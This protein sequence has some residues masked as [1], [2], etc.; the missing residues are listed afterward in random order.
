MAD[1]WV[2]PYTDFGEGRDLLPVPVLRAV[3]PVSAHGRG[4]TVAA[5][6]DT[7]G[8]ITVVS[9][10]FLAIAGGDPAVVGS[11]VI[12]LGGRRYEANLY[13]LS[14]AL[15]H[16]TDPEAAPMS[17]TSTVAVLDPWPHEGTAMIL[18]HAGFLDRFTVTFG[19]EGFAVEA[20]EV[21]RRRFG[22]TGTT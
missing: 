18:G 12:R 17:W 5:I 11:T 20:G 9:A 2:F 14:M 10:A 13:E 3:V 1:V 8:P 22:A 15:H 21:F 7:G 6:I 4:P 19:P 16:G